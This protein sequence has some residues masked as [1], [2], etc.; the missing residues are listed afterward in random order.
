MLH[1]DVGI[2]TALC[3]GGKGEGSFFFFRFPLRKFYL[4][5]RAGGFFAMKGLILLAPAQP[6]EANERSRVL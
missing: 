4:D 1:L 3:G 5:K 6:W 2:G